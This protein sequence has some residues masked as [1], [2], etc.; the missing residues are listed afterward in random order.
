MRP[1]MLTLFYL[2]LFVVGISI[3]AI[4]AA[5]AIP[6]FLEAGRVATF[7]GGS[8]LG[9]APRAAI[10]PWMILGGIFFGVLFLILVMLLL[11]K[12]LLM[13]IFHRSEQSGERANDEDTDMLRQLWEAQDRMEERLTNLETILLER[14]N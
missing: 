13:K 11:M 6:N 1:I 2:F 12:E 9:L 5:I 10:L 8:H 14:R 3:V 4:L 7:T